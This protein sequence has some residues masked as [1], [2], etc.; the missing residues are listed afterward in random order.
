MGGDVCVPGGE[1][2]FDTAPRNKRCSIASARRRQ[3]PAMA[4]V[5]VRRVSAEFLSRSLSGLGYC[6]LHSASARAARRIVVPDLNGPRST[7]NSGELL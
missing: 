3:Y 2:A 5:A 7:S 6:N 4:L 1:H